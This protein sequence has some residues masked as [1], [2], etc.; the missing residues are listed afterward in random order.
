MSE[1]IKRRAR[2]KKLDR[3]RR[4]GAPRVLDLFAGCGGLSLG[5]AT[6]GFKIAAGLELDDQA[7][8]THAEN[9]ISRDENPSLHPSG[10]DIRETEPEDL[11]ADVEPGQGVADKIDVIIGGPPCQS[12]ARIG[13]AKLRE[14]DENPDAFLKDH[15][16]NLYLRYLDYVRKLEPLS[17]VIENV[18]GALNHG[19]HNI[20]E[21]IC[22][23]LEAHGYGCRYTLLNAAFYGVPQ[24]RERM[25]L[26]AWA[27]EIDDRIQFPDPTHSITLPP[28]YDHVRNDALKHVRANSLFEKGSQRGHFVEMD[29]P[30]QDL[31]PAVTVEEALTDLPAIK[32]HRKGDPPQGRRKFDELERYPDSCELT[33][34]GYLMRNWPGFESH[35]GIYD[36][37]SGV[38]HTPRDYRIFERMEPGD[39]YPEAHQKALNL[40]EEKI[41]EKRKYSQEVKEDSKKYEEMKED[42][43]PPYDPSKFPNKW[44][45]MEADEPART[46]TAHLGK[47]TYSHIHYDDNQARTISVREAARLQS[48]PDGFVFS[49]SMSSAFRQIGNA[50]PPLVSYRLA[51][52]VANTLCFTYDRSL[53]DPFSRRSSD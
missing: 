28:G 53:P 43:V 42:L 26:V 45:K 37:K 32:R 40:L 5:F 7:A 46:L 30:T 23:A 39:Q 20:G 9:F 19:N 4:G 24:M 1:A 38:R 41:N 50:V 27:E 6:A 8:Q 11:F 17:I 34:Y 16:S 52:E 22:E 14:V 29:T 21:E 10:R 49:S 3:L 36:H 18:P 15:R 48:F 35:D 47:D 33:N 13:R 44:R 25:F 31:P 2:T 51:G 12:F